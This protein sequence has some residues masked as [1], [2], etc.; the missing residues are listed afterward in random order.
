[1]ETIEIQDALSIQEDREEE[2]TFFGKPPQPW[3]L[4]NNWAKPK[5]KRK[6]RKV[7]IDLWQEES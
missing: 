4:R 5:R 7:E 6:S 1:M 3:Q 2:Q